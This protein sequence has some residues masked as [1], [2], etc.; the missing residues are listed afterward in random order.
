M[1]SLWS[2]LSADLDLGGVSVR[3]VGSPSLLS[4]DLDLGGVATLCGGCNGTP[5]IPFAWSGAT[6]G[7]P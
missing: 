4:I 3:L 2:L 1:T 6:D 7:V 5:A